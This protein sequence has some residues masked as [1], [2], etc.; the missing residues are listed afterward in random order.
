MEHVYINDNGEVA[1][2]RHRHGGYYLEQAVAARPEGQRFDTPAGSW[3]RVEGDEAEAY[4]VRCN[5]CAATARHIAR[6]L[7]DGH[8]YEGTE[9]HV[10]VDD[11]AAAAADAGFDYDLNEQ[12]DLDVLAEAQRI[13]LQ[14]VVA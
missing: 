1:C 12:R 8:G 7:R 3:E 2:G 6:A 5:G 13:T 4:G 10:V 14:G 11:L 9:E